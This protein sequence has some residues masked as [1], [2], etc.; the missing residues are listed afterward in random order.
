MPPANI[1]AGH[2]GRIILHTA[3][4]SLDPPLGVLFKIRMV[5]VIRTIRIVIIKYNHC[6]NLDIVLILYVVTI[7]SVSIQWLSIQCLLFMYVR[8]LFVSVTY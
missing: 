6:D 4:V 5:Q 7:V 8:Q 1:G 3:G 2:W